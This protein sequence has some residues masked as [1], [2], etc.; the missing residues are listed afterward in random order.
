MCSAAAATAADD[1]TKPKWDARDKYLTE[2]RC[3]EAQFF[4]LHLAY[5]YDLF[6]LFLSYLEAE[7][8]FFFFEK[9]LQF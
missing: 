3:L 9:H 1:D 8:I 6:V 7:N 2:L 5:A 4:F